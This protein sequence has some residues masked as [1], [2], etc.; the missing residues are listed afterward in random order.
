[1]KPLPSRKFIASK[2]VL[3]SKLI[4]LKKINGLIFYYLMPDVMGIKLPEL[5]QDCI[6]HTHRIY[7]YYI[8]MH[9]IYVIHI[10]HI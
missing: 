5:S 2:T 10:I 4:G 3:I 7:A 1:M 6:L 9:I 8:C